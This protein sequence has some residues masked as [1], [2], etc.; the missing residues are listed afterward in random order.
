VGSYPTSGSLISSVQNSRNNAAREKGLF[1]DPL[2]KSR[3][4]YGVGNVADGKRTKFRYLA[5]VSLNVNQERSAAL[6]ERHYQKN[7]FEGIDLIAIEGWSS[8]NIAGQQFQ[9]AKQGYAIGVTGEV[10]DAGKLAY[11]EGFHHVIE[12]PRRVWQVINA[13]DREGGDA[14]DKAVRG[15]AESLRPN[16]STNSSTQPAR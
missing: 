11:P 1:K 12:L 14:F 10:Y 2:G 7:W 13:V 3:P 9:E 6:V 5:R 16:A 8:G 15:L 4:F